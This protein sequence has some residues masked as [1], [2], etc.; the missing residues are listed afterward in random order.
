PAFSALIRTARSACTVRTLS[1]LSSAADA[2]VKRFDV[3]A[4]SAT[5]RS[6]QRLTLTLAGSALLAA[7]MLWSFFSK[8]ARVT[9][10]RSERR[11]RSLVEHSTEL[12]AVVDERRR[13]RFLTPA[14]ER[15]LGHS[16]EELLG[17]AL[18]D[19]VH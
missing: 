13:I 10:E 7:L 8:R 19:L 3:N 6:H 18:L 17:T 5:S 2:R 1:D 12:V 11:F 4:Q 14:W 9:L 16:G 15:T